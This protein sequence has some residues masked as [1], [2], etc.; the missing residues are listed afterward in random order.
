MTRDET[1]QFFDRWMD[2]WLRRDVEALML[3]HTE[4]CVL[5]SPIAGKVTGRVAIENVYRAF[6]TSFPDVTIDNPQLIVEGDRA[7]QLVTFSGTNT[8]GFM[9]MQPTGK[10][11]SFAA[12]LIY[13]MRDG[14]IAHERRI[15]DFTGFLLE[16]GVLKAKPI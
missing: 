6:V 15:Y 2:A 7:V 10:R 14:L 16:I 11:F 5:E 3:A 13:T 12:V 8:G 1:Q 9:G 4:D